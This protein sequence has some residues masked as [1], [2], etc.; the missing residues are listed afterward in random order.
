MKRFLAVLMLVVMMCGCVGLAEEQKFDYTVLEK[1]DGYTYDKSDKTWLYNGHYLKE[2]SDA[3][4]GVGLQADGD[5]NTVQGVVLYAKA[6]DNKNETYGIIQ[7][8]TILAGEVEIICKLMDMDG[9]Q[10][11]IMTA[12]NEEALSAIV[13]AKEISIKVK[14][15]ISTTAI[16]A[17]GIRVETKIVSIDLEPTEKDLEEFI[18]AAKTIYQNNLL[19]YACGFSEKTIQFAQEN[20]PITVNK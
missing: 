16:D 19:S 17:T 15:S 6:L 8:V 10:L 18:T 1:L 13:N 12:T 20:Y 11:T 2:F 7:E 4:I 5:E 9:E 14:M 3:T